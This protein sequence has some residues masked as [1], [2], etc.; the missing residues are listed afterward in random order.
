MVVIRS[1]ADPARHLR[2]LEMPEWEALLEAIIATL[3]SL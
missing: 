3:T 1:H 2:R